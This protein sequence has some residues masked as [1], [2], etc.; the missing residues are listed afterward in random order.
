MSDPVDEVREF[1]ASE[2]ETFECPNCGADDWE[3]VSTA[4]T[5]TNFE[6][7][8]KVTGSRHW[9]TTNKTWG[10]RECGADLNISMNIDPDD[11]AARLVQLRDDVGGSLD[12]LQEKQ[13]E[14]FWDE[15]EQYAVDHEDEDQEDDESDSFN[16]GSWTND[17]ESDAEF[18]DYSGGLRDR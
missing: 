15:L 17:D 5:P 2:F 3:E 11:C 18:D 1:P 16:A 13:A 9:I 12:D 14:Q 7:R 8:M 6:G 10:C 4:L